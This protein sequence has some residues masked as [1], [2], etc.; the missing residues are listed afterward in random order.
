VVEPFL[1]LI[2]DP[3][4]HNCFTTIH[5]LNHHI[6]AVH[7]QIKIH[8]CNLCD[9]SSYYKMDLDKHSK[10]IHVGAKEFK[11]DEFDECDK[12]FTRNPTSQVRDPPTRDNEIF[13]SIQSIRRLRDSAVTC[14]TTLHT[15]EV[16]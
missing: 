5:S 7:K 1:Q 2:N 10:S 9:Y 3:M 11:C 4:S 12:A 6:N 13:I 14:V 16:I 15:K 8:S